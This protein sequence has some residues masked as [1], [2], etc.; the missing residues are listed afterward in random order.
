MTR[1]DLHD[2]TKKETSLSN[3]GRAISCQAKRG[4]LRRAISRQ[5]KVT[6]VS[7]CAIAIVTFDIGLHKVCVRVG[8]GYV[9]TKF[10]RMDSLPNFV[11][12]GAPLPRASRARELRYKCILSTI[13]WSLGL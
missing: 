4:L 1:C 5:K 3:D 12:H 6:C 11:T 13:L 10:S 8:T 7:S 2:V 9:I